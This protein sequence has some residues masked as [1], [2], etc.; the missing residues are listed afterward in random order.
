MK[1]PRRILFW[2]GLTGLILLAVLL[3]GLIHPGGLAFWQAARASTGS[4]AALTP[5]QIAAIQGAG[6]LLLLAQ[7]AN[8]LCLPL[9]RR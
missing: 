1:K 3:S 8:S 2:A 9:V 5:G 4:A 7:P 6:Q